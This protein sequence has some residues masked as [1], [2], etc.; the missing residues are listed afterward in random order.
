M[1]SGVEAC[2]FELLP[3]LAK[4]G[5]GLIRQRDTASIDE[6]I[7]VVHAEP[8]AFHVERSNGEPQRFAFFEDGIPRRALRLVPNAGSESLE[9]LFSGFSVIGV[10]H[11]CF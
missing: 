9:V 8:N 4:S 6:S 1:R 10:G 7:D 5:F 11:A 2:G 3:D